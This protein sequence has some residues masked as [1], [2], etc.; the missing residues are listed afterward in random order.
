MQHQWEAINALDHKVPAKVQY[1]MHQS[2]SDSMKQQVMWVLRNLPRPFNVSGL[3]ERFEG[4]VEKL[5]GIKQEILSEPAQDAFVSRRDALKK[6]GVGHELAT[7]VSAFEVLASG[8]DIIEVAEKAE[9]RVDYV[10]AVH[11]ALGDRLGFDWLRQRADRIQPE[12]HWDVLSVRSELEDL[13]DQQRAL[14]ERVCLEAGEK[15]ARQATK[16]W[17]AKQATQI[18]RAERLIEDLSSSGGLTVAKLS[19]ATRHL[20]SIL[21]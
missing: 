20:R 4:P 17:A 8:P 19:F 13:A 5:F 21:R 7:F 3:V 16:D 15:S 18:I 6:T 10:A 2:V 1:D 11:F 14:V 12:N 9:K